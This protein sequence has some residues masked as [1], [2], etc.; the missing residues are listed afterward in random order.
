MGSWKML[1]YEPSW[2]GLLDLFIIEIYK[3]LNILII[4]KTKVLLPY[5]YTEGVT[6]SRK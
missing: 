4:T 6:R 3:F 2:H 5:A 1:S